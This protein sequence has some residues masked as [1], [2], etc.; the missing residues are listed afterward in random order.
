MPKTATTPV[1]PAAAVAKDAHWTATRDKLRARQRPTATLT[2]CDDDALRKRLEEAR[3]RHA[4]A[5]HNAERAPDNDVLQ[6]ALAHAVDTLAAAQ[7]AFDEA[8]IVLSF[9]AI[10]R[11]DFEDLKK[12]HPP[13][14]DGAEDGQIVNVETFAPELIA[15]TSQDGITPDDAR[16]YL[17]EWA[18]GEA[19]ALFNTA[20]DLQAVVRM[21]LGKG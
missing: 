4:R 12:A 11:T 2:I 14:E 19:A 1:P 13:T 18:E 15:A 9:T 7:A 3:T 5:E 6:A 21:D 17:D 10:G 20:W 8:A 16:T